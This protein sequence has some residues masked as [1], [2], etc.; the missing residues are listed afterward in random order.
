MA[1]A[2]FGYCAQAA[3]AFV[4]EAAANDA[5]VRF[6]EAVQDIRLGHSENGSSRITGE[7][8]SDRCKA[9]DGNA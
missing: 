6:S 1:S 9:S 8:L 2:G 5:D 3:E 7:I 4:E